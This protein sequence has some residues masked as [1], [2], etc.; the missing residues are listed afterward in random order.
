MIPTTIA[1]LVDPFQIYH[2]SLFGTDKFTKNQRYQNAG[3]INSYLAD[4]KEGF[5]SII[6]GT[7][8]TEN[9]DPTN[10]ANKMN[11]DRTLSLS[12]S[13]GFPLEQEITAR[14]ALS[15]NNVRHVL[16]GII[17]G[18]WSSQSANEWRKNKVFPEYLYDNN[19][20]NDSP[21]LLSLS[22]L[23]YSTEIALNKSTI[24]TRNIDNRN[25]WYQRHLKLFDKWN[26]PDNI[27]KLK[28]LPQLS[29]ISPRSPLE[30]SQFN[31]PS[32]DKH[33]TSV[34]QPHCNSAI[35]FNLVIVPS[36][37][38]G[39]KILGKKSFYRQLQLRRY[40]VENL[41]QCGNVAIFAFDLVDSITADLNNYKDYKH[42]R[43]DINRHITEQIAK[44]N[45][46]LTI[47]NITEYENTLIEKV[48]TY[49][50]YSSA[51]Y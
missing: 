48:N 42:Y 1:I 32:V 47:E 38:I 29:G 16:W 36:S 26:S 34:I 18:A 6:L 44:G 27:S 22:T 21:Y 3:V 39:L 7:S 23:E 17:P 5:D 46:R 13:G 41:Q 25:L 37:R 49:E 19:L 31:Y 45:H 35:D 24:F 20:S 2:K 4:K 43:A 50:L 9:F 33:L 10:V 15:T 8:M 14:R 11:W 40:L 28:K 12:L 30:R 51:R